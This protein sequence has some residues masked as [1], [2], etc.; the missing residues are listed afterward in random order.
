MTSAL[1]T[2]SGT[3]TQLPTEDEVNDFSSKVDEVSIL[4]DG[5]AKGTISPQYIDSKLES[6]NS[7]LSKVTKV[8]SSPPGTLNR[9][10][11]DVM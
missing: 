1:S 2:A 3:S 6:G 10:V 7:K 8:R 9:L 11:R 5:L 4:I